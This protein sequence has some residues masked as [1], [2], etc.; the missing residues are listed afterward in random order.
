MWFFWPFRRKARR[1][2]PVGRRTNGPGRFFGRQYAAGIPYALPSDLDEANRLDFQHF[3]L[4]QAFQGNYVAPIRVPSSMLDV[5]T[6]TGRW[7][8][9][10]ALAF[11]GANVVG[12]DIKEPAADERQAA[13]ALDLRPNNYVFVP[14]NVLEGIPFPD[15][16]FDFVH[17]RLLFFAI[18]ADR[19]PVLMRELYRVTRPGGWVEV[20]EGHFGYEP[21]GPTAQRIADIML[22]ALL[23]RGIDPRSSAAID[24][25]LREAGFRQVRMRSA[26]LPVGE[27]GGRLGKLVAADVA[28]FNQSAKPL[29]LSQGLSERDIAQL[30]AA[31][32]RECEE[33]HCAW[34]FHIA[35]GQ[36]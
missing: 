21:M 1:A 32:L 17:Q 23:S 15:A 14:G 31:M 18:P 36:R 35:Y 26:N 8:K 4:R 16:S 27:W 10:M 11:P 13:S 12:M 33:L 9:E 5:G 2:Q 25:F 29:L 19:W 24:H 7:A 6:G 30:D 20:V 28:A 34:P 22:P 3:I